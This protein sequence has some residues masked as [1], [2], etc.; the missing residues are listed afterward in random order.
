MEAKDRLIFA[1]DVE[2]LPAAEE[3]AARLAGVV[4]RLKVGLELFIAAGPPAVRA[5]AATG[6]RVMLDLKLHDIPQTVANATARACALDADLLTIHTSG[7]RRMME[8]AAQAARAAGGRTK[9]LGVTVLTSME[10]KD[11][12]EVGVAGEVAALVRQRALL[13][14]DSGLDG[15]VASPQEAALIRAAVGEGFL[16]VTPGVRPASGAGG[17]DQR[18]VATPAAALRAGADMIVVGRPI[19]DAPDPRAAAAAIVA[20]LGA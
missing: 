9:L 8:A 4:T 5:M 2:T 3:L 16:I 17:D 1:L 10:A 18:R 13:A 14:R 20:E 19:K 15:V 6:A 11:L 12:A 7:G